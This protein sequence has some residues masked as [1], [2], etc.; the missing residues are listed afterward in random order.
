MPPSS[1]P[2]RESHPDPSQGCM[3]LPH[4]VVIPDSSPWTGL[5]AG[6]LCQV[7]GAVWASKRC[8]STACNHAYH[9][10]LPSSFVTIVICLIDYHLNFKL[11]P[12]R[13][14]FPFPSDGMPF[15]CWTCKVRLAPPLPGSSRDPRSLR[16]PGGLG[17]CR[18][19]DTKSRRNRTEKNRTIANAG[20]PD[21]CARRKVTTQAPPP[22]NPAGGWGL[23]LTWK[24][25]QQDIHGW[26]CPHCTHDQAPMQ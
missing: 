8:R 5:R 13:G 22:P 3:I 11:F 4:P 20:T 15:L 25:T 18:K 19:K 16:L 6:L 10:S 21:E 17:C 12:E 23:P 14:H 2:C 1:I 26:P 9:C 7:C 24:E